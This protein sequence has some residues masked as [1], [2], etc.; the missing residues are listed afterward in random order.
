MI[1]SRLPGFYQLSVAER[2]AKLAET[3]ELDVAE[4]EAMSSHGSLSLEQ[5]DKM[6]ENAVGIYSLPIGI[7]ANFLINGKEYLVPMAIEEP[8]VVAAASFGA[9]I[10]RDAGGFTTSSSEPVMIGQIQIVGC[11]DFA[12][13]EAAV[14]E[15]APRLVAYAN[16]E[17]VANIVARG[18]GVRGI[19]T[20]QLGEGTPYGQ[21]LVVHVLIDTCDAMGANLINT[22][23]EGLAPEIERLTGGKV[24]LRIL[25]NLADRRLAKARCVIPPHCFDTANYSGEDVVDGIVHA[26]NFAIL[27][28]YRAVTHNK[29]VMNGVD[30]V[31]MATANDWRSVEAAAH[32]YAAR[33]GQYRAMTEWYRNADGHLVGELEL[34]LAVGTV[35]AAISLHPMAKIAL[36]FLRTKTARELAEVMVCV[37]LAQ[38]L[39]AIRALATDGIQK[40]HMA[41]HSRTVAMTAGA[42]GDDID[43]VAAELVK[44]RDVTLSRAQ[45]IMALR[46]PERV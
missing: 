27:D 21:M 10:V 42:T 35:G 11:P 28:P 36:K 18:G 12:A 15:A 34:P 17:L 29:G 45:Q 13:A 30:A 41:L 33:S 19:E 44:A 7:G 40:G 8:S 39:S 6:I 5:A 14:L 37:G 31:V 32:A 20:R 22:T 46:Y 23:V 25:S 9:K 1:T 16:Q 38:N 24:Y 26:Q 3:Y 2:I 43:S 4:V